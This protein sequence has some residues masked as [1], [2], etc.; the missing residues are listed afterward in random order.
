MD[1]NKEEEEV[2]AHGS[3]EV[4]EEVEMKE[5]L[6]K[7]VEPPPRDLEDEF[8]KMIS[9]VI[10]EDENVKKKIAE[11]GPFDYDKRSTTQGLDLV[12]GV[13]SDGETYYGFVYS[14]LH[15]SDAIDRTREYKGLVVYPNGAIFEGHFINGEIMG[16]GRKVLAKK[17]YIVGRFV[18]DKLN[19]MGRRVKSDGTYYEG[20]FVNGIPNGRGLQHFANGDKYSGEFKDGKYHGEGTLTKQRGKYIFKGTFLNGR[21]NGQGSYQEVG[22]SKSYVGEFLNGKEH[23]IGIAISKEG[24]RY[25]GNF[26]NGK[27]HG[28]GTLVE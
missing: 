10:P 28:K 22:T 8:Y 16:E 11:L 20:N 17:E 5:E 14:L 7:I 24:D 9:R 21:L 25:E 26:V 15:L 18:G 2:D 27:R 4:R 1:S 12:T 23:G 6:P 13:K 19:G 3:R